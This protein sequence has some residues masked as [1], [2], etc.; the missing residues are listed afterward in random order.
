MAKEARA[1]IKINRALESSGWRFFDDENGPANVALEPKVKVTQKSVD[2]LGE[3]FEHASNGFVDFLMLEETGRPLAVLE[4]KAES[5]DPLV[6]K[7]QARK[8]AR[9]QNCRFVILSNGNL[10]YFWDLERGNPHIITALPR[11]GSMLAAEKL[12]PDPDRI[13]GERI[14]RDYVVLTQRPGYANEAGWKNEAERDD[15][16]AANKLK[17][18]RDYQVRALHRIQEAVKEGKD[19]IPHLG[20]PG[21]YRE[22]RSAYCLAQAWTAANDLPELVR[23]TMDTSPTLAGARLLEGFFEREVSLQDGARHSQTDLLCLLDVRGELAVMSVEGKVDE[24]FGPLIS[25]ELTTASSFKKARIERLSGLLGLSLSEA[26]PLRYQLIHRTASAIYE[27][28][29]FHART[30]VMMVH[31]FHAED[32]GSADY[33]AFAE[34]LGFGRAEPTHMVGPRP[35]QGVDLYLGWTADRPSKR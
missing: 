28:Q 31:S 30:A 27:A 12:A 19:V 11:P 25:K 4:A 7:E 8:Y 5:K 1:R 24:S 17:F 6:G 13:V 34:A 15:F 35:F 14:E 33:A 18:L 23:L 9:S 32:A 20:S 3:D 2:A 16:T 22:G 10:H 21:H 29:R 26:M